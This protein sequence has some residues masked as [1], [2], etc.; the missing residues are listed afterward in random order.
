MPKHEYL[1]ARVETEL[2]QRIKK[3]SERDCVSV[4][5]VVDDCLNMSIEKREAW[6][7]PKVEVK[8]PK[9]PTL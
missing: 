9:P 7:R 5:Q 8:K 4:S 6:C 1:T 3:L 2:K